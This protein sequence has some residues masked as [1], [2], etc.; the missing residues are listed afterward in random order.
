MFIF[1][2]LRVLAWPE[3]YSIFN[4]IVGNEFLIE[5]GNGGVEGVW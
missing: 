4:S 3:V 5:N 1:L 2:A